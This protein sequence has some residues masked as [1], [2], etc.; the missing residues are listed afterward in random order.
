MSEAEEYAALLAEEDDVYFK[1][2]SVSSEGGTLSLLR[3]EL[4]TSEVSSMP[5]KLMTNFSFG[6]FDMGLAMRGI[7][8]SLATAVSSEGGLL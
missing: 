6:D 4:D 2:P 5:A 1:Q 7:V 3:G 8:Q